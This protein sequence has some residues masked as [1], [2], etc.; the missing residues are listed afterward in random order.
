MTEKMTSL[1][2]QIK[3][4]AATFHNVTVKPTFVNFLFGKNGVGKSTFADAFRHS[5]CLEWQTGVNPNNYTIL[6]YDRNFI[7]RNL[8]NYG[9]LK[10]V[11]TLSE[12]NAETRSE[13]ENKTEERK[14]ISIEGKTVATNRDKKK[15]EQEPLK[16]A[17]EDICWNKTADIRK[18]FDRTQNGKKKKIQF[19]NEVLTGGH[20]PVE[21]KTVKIQELYDVAYDPNAKKYSLFKKSTDLNDTYDLSGV[22][23]L[24]EVVTSHSDTQFAKFMKALNATEWVKKG[25]DEFVAHSKGKCPFCQSALPDSFEDNIAKAFDEEYQKALDALK[26][27]GTNYKNKMSALVELLKSNLKE[28]YP[29]VDTTSYEKTIAQLEATVA[30]N[31]K[32]IA[33]KQEKPGEVFSLIDTDSIV[34]QIDCEIEDINKTIQENNDIVSTKHDK[35]LECFNM[36]WEEIAFMLKDEVSSYIKS[37]EDIENEIKKLKKQVAA[38]QGKYRN[39]TDEINQLNLKVIDTLSTVNSMNAYLKDSGFEGFTLREKK[40]VKGTYEVI[41]ED[42]KVAEH[43]SEGERNFIAF[44]YFYH[45]VR[46]SQ[47][48]T[49]SGKDKIVVIDDPVSS[50]D[51]SSLFIVSALVREMLGVCSNNVSGAAIRGNGTEYQ[52][53]YIQQIFV[54]THNAFFHREITYNQVSHYRYVSFYKLNKKNNVSSIKQCVIEAKTISEKD[55]NYNPVQNSY[56]ALWREYETV[57]SPIPLMNVIRRILEYY[58]IQLCAIDNDVL[59]KTV[60]DAIREQVKNE[61]TGGVPDY[62]KYHLAQAMLSYIDRSDAFNEGLHFVDENIDCDQYRDVFRTIFNVMNQG[63]HYKRMMNEID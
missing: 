1:I 7:D 30:E 51:S 55:R 27:Y 25:H 57:D 58:F 28:V 16:K 24:G 5:E 63:Q 39:L 43:L 17:F 56:N 8:A 33:K 53:K 61:T 46:G 60:L 45:L 6:V 31:E 52:G 50:M 22:T 54:L 18:R 14:N 13:I 23:Y 62:T 34:K 3:I 47:S 29:K 38:L 10:G 12:E 2:K 11:F 9:D 59:S 21:H 44:L 35:Q 41:R 4:D 42:G 37:K 36:V 49:D 15:E 20:R 26:D 19:A 48:E 32:I 40:G